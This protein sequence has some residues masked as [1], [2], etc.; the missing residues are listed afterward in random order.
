MRGKPVLIAL[1]LLIFYSS[2]SF[3]FVPSSL[4]EVTVMYHCLTLLFQSHCPLTFDLF[5]TF[6]HT[7]GSWPLSTIVTP[8]TF[9]PKGNHVLVTG[10]WQVPLVNFHLYILS[11]Y[12]ENLSWTVECFFF[13]NPFWQCVLYYLSFLCVSLYTVPPVHFK[14]VRNDF[15]N[16]T[17]Q[18]LE[19]R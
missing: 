4:E 10:G 6:P 15:R 14:K 19:V 2:P 9:A 3:S 18:K 16:Q 8:L 17:W 13:L 1:Y 5:L 7:L 11:G 12:G